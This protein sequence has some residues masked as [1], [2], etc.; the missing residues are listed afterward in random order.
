MNDP[1]KKGQAGG[2]ATT[3]TDMGPD[4]DTSANK[5][6]NDAGKDEGTLGGFAEES[7]SESEDYFTES[8]D[9]APEE[10]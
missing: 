7:E 3:D 8:Y 9:D 1:K 6:T 2:E 10:S 5:S 4:T